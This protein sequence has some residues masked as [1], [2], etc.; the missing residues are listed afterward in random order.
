VG[1]NR[2]TLEDLEVCPVIDQYLEYIQKI[3]SLNIEFAGEFLD[4]A[5]YL[6]WTKSCVLLPTMPGFLE[7]G[8][9]DPVGD[10]KEM[11]RE[12]MAVRHAAEALGRMPRLYS[13]RFPRG[14]S[15]REEVLSSMNMG[16]LMQAVH[17]IRMR[18]RKYVIRTIGPKIS[19]RAMM[20][21]LHSMLDKRSPIS[22]SKV[23]GKRQDRGEKIAVF[24][25]AL[26]LSRSALAGIIQEALF[27]EI[28]LVKKG[29]SDKG[30]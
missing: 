19:L 21:R 28:Y 1:K 9:V 16:A 15:P 4:M 12:Y 30:E 25:A 11:L 22:L 24:L 6:I 2:F 14:G 5:S 20:A 23:F 13:D 8:G 26:E 27:S 10:L 29:S 3:Q 18:T 17:D 7:D